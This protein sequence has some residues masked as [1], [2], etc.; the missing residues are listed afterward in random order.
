LASPDAAIREEAQYALYGNIYHQGT[1]YE[2]TAYVVPFL[3]ELLQA[4]QVEDKEWLLYY[5]VPLANDYFY[6][7][8]HQHLSFRDDNYPDQRDLDEFQAELMDEFS[9]V[10]ATNRAV[11]K[12][13]PLYLELAEQHPVPVVRMAALYTLSSLSSRSVL[14]E[15]TSRLLARLTGVTSDSTQELDQQVRAGLVYSLG[16]LFAPF[17]KELSPSQ[18]A[19]TTPSEQLRAELQQS[20]ANYQ[21]YLEFLKTSLDSVP[22]K[23][24]EQ[25]ESKLVQLVAAASLPRW[26]G[27]QAPAQAIINKR[28]GLSALADRGS[29]LPFLTV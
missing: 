14:T 17:L 29:R 1:L 4:P 13:I 28:R 19:M 11:R 2:A 20:L 21:L 6:W 25:P 12:G 27:D 10:G 16:Y 8:V 3:L 23:P 26:L 5:L 15:V 22:L 24:G 7:D 9:W 18:T